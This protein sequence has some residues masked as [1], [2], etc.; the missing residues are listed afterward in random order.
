MKVTVVWN[1]RQL[2]GVA[3]NMATGRYDAPCLGKIGAGG[4]FYVLGADA[5]TGLVD[6]V[7]RP[8]CGNS[9]LKMSGHWI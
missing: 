3:R 8:L 6:V 1:S 2:Y 4:W 5:M 9:K 7:R